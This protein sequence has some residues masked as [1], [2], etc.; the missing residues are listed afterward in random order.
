VLASVQIAVLVL[1]YCAW[2]PIYWWIIMNRIC[3]FYSLVLM[4]CTVPIFCVAVQAQSVNGCHLSSNQYDPNSTSNPYGRCGSPYSPD[5]INNPYGKYGSPYS[6]TSVNNPY[7]TDAPRIKASDGT[8]LGK[9]STNQYDSDSTSNPYGPH[10]SSY[11]PKSVNNPYSTYGSPY[12]SQSP[13][14]PYS[15]TAPTL[16]NGSEGDKDQ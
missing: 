6:P 8:D 4:L 10:G 12:S 3:L 1:F 11:S 16:S 5:S 7:A 13:N 2:R 14:D 9:L 15:T